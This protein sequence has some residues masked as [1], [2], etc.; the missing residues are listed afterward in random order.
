MKSTDRVIATCTVSGA[1][2]AFLIWFTWDLPWQA[3]GLGFLVGLSVYANMTAPKPKEK[4][5]EI[6]IH[7][8]PGNEM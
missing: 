3:L 1:I 5:K 6:V 2:F 4:E 8:L 7:S